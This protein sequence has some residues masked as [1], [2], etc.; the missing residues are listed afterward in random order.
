MTKRKFFITHDL[1]ARIELIE[2]CCIKRMEI[3]N[4][5]RAPLLIVSAFHENKI[6][7]GNEEAEGKE[8]VPVEAFT[9]KEQDCEYCE[10]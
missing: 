3:L 6:D 7:C 9:F 5:D 1:D 4:H 10:H 2:R 8:V